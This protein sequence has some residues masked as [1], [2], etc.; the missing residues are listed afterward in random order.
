MSF[1]IS[2][3]HKKVK[4]Y[5]QKKEKRHGLLKYQVPPSTEY[6]LANVQLFDGMADLICT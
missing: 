4:N 1:T 2:S 6:V 5:A 3:F